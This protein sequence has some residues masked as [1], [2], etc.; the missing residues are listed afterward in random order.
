M[1]INNP[2]SEAFGLDIGDL[3]LKLVRLSAHKKWPSDDISYKIESAKIVS[4]PAGYIVNGE[5]QQPEMVRKKLLQLLG[6]EGNDKSKKAASPWVVTDL[7]EPKTFLTS[8][9]LEMPSEQVTQEDVEYQSQKHLPFDLSEA[10][11]DWQVIKSKEKS[12]FTRVLIGAVQKSIA[13]SYVYLLESAGLQPI[14]LEIESLAIA[15]GLISDSNGAKAILD[16]GATRSAI[17]IYDQGGVR[18]STAINFSGEI[19]TMALE[20]KLNLDYKTAE[21]LKIKSGLNYIKEHHNYLKIVDEL[22]NGLVKDIKRI[23][24]Y[25]QEHYPDSHPI[26]KIELCGGMA[27]MQNLS[28]TLGRRLKIKCELTSSWRNMDTKN[29]SESEKRQGLTMV[30]ATGLAMRAIINPYNE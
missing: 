7:P 29:L 26:E 3:S 11:L 27:E 9:E 12:K 2:F 4:L 10:Y 19:I 28:S 17:I 30:S 14:A 1:F 25:Y 6:R 18:F 15:R 5:I 21:E 20:Q 22:I 24:L 16:L 13:D 8:I 23:I